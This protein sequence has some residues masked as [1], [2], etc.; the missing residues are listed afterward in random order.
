MTQRAVFRRYAAA[1]HRACSQPDS[2][3]F[4]R[5]W[6]ELQGWL[7][8]SAR[9]LES[10]SETQEE[11]VQETLLALQSALPQSATA[12]LAYA[13][14]TLKRKQIDL[15]RGGTAEKRGGGNVLSLEGL[16]GRAEEGDGRS[17]DEKLQEYAISAS[18]ANWRT[19]ERAVSDQEVRRQLRQFGLEHLPT[20]LQR[21][22]FE[23]HFLDGLTP[24]EI[25]GLLGKQPHEIRLIKARTVKKIKEL[26]PTAM[27]QLLEIIGGLAP[28]E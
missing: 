4:E 22:V 2:A 27:Q 18:S 13:M 23:A 20:E 15:N 8:K 3:D 24:A 14:Q 12:F 25:A 19:I 9:H 16:G 11:M 1:L 21:Q 17:W 7:A 26:S 5:G 10:H 28:D 6:L